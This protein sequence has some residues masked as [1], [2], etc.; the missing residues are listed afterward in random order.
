M[1][2][3]DR[4]LLDHCEQM[5]LL[6][7]PTDL[8]IVA[9][10]RFVGQ[11]L[12]Y[13]VEELLTRTI[14]DIESALQDV[15]YWEDVRNG[16]YQDIEVQ[17]GLYLCADGSTLT[18]RKSVRVVE[19]DDRVLAAELAGDALQQPAGELADVRARLGRSGEGDE[20]DAR[21]GHQVIAEIAARPEDEVHHALRKAGLLE[22]LHQA[23]R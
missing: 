17:E 14:T 19:H 21:M 15:F 22:D 9:A 2:D 8:R 23:D 10:N 4:L 5:L 13:S 6:V 16:Q 11:A 1:S 12:G 20:G 3:F 7:A 18:V